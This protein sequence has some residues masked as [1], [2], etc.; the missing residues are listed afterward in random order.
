MSDLSQKAQDIVDLIHGA[1]GPYLENETSFF[2]QKR[3]NPSMKDARM[4]TDCGGMII[5]KGKMTYGAADA[6]AASVDLSDYPAFIAALTPNAYWMSPYE[7][8]QPPGVHFVGQVWWSIYSYLTTKG[9][10]CSMTPAS[11]GKGHPQ[12]RGPGSYDNGLEYL[13]DEVLKRLVADGVYTADPEW[14]YFVRS[15]S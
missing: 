14:R 1:P 3:V 6:L 5:T 9:H 10:I 12:A 15:S 7:K 2:G 11:Y 8:P 13:Y 4:E